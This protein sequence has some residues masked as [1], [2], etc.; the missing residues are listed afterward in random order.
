MMP[1]AFT[2]VEARGPSVTQTTITVQQ[3]DPAHAAKTHYAKMARSGNVS[4]LLNGK[5]YASERRTATFI[6]ECNNLPQ[7]QSINSV[8]GELGDDPS[9]LILSSTPAS[10]HSADWAI[11]SRPDS[12]IIPLTTKVRQVQYTGDVDI[13]VGLSDE[14][15]S[16]RSK[17]RVVLAKTNGITGLRLV[18][19]EPNLA[20]MKAQSGTGRI[21]SDAVRASFVELKRGDESTY[22]I[23]DSATN[24]HIR[25]TLKR[26][27]DEKSKEMDPQTYSK[28]YSQEISK[29]NQK[30]SVNGVMVEQD[31]LVLGA[32]LFAEF[33][34]YYDKNIGNRVDMIHPERFGISLRAASAGRVLSG[35]IR[36]VVELVYVHSSSIDAILAIYAIHNSGMISSDQLHSAGHDTHK[37]ITS[38]AP[39]M[40]LAPAAP[41]QGGGGMSDD[42]D[43]DEDDE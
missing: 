21:S 13:V 18:K 41:S 3:V 27:L 7:V 9:A 37:L 43:D 25:E 38:M 39:Q 35:S 42:E 17:K 10:T 6:V 19:R 34:E 2:P 5:H 22:E 40:T 23:A 12:L 16:I 14:A 4:G 8:P 36:L 26:F 31:Y 1:D 28:M 11:G 33:M 15:Q 24:M 30:R 29:T 20:Y 32:R